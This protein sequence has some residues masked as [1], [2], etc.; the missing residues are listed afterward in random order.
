MVIENAVIVISSHVA[1]GSVGNR[2]MVF[3]LER[4]GFTV[5]AVP[6]VFLPHHPGLGAAERI[7][8]DDAAFGR[9]LG[10]LIGGD[11]ATRVAGIVSGYLAS[12]GQAR[13]VA[14][15]V[16]AVKAQRP[17]ALYLCDPVIGDA[18][19][20]YVAPQIAESVRDHL[21]PLADAATPNAFECAWLAGHNSSGEPDLVT[22]A[23]RLAP[24][25]VLVTSA[26]AL[27]RRQ[28]G[29][30]LV[31]GSESMLFEHRRIETP[32]KGTGDLLAALLLTH[33]LKGHAWQAAAE[34]AIAS[35]FE[36]LAGSAKAGADDLMLAA[37]QTALVEPRTRIGVRRLG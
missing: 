8:P 25:V 17:E 28:I 20:V 15:L 21:V 9:L 5:W 26:P 31:A 23:S 10:A 6:T 29:N 3:A 7:V 35:V 16:A 27:M 14:A 34:M 32:I 1:R 19:G 11:R 18:G 37:L 24:P 13:A 33:R 12:A 2:A 4:L 36:V 22:L 30:L